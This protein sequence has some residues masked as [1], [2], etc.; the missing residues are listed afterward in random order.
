MR[1]EVETKEGK[2][3]MTIQQV[4]SGRSDRDNTGG[5]E[6]RSGRNANRNDRNEH[7]LDRNEG[8][9]DTDD[10]MPGSRDSGWQHWI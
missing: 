8:K 1:Q 9:N 3:E 2:M 4:A 6:H 10:R 7:R 5:N